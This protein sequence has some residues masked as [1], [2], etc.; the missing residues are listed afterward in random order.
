MAILA[1][2]DDNAMAYGEAYQDDSTPAGHF[3]LVAVMDDFT[4]VYLLEGEV[5]D[6]TAVIKGRVELDT[7]GKA[8]NKVYLNGNLG[9]GSGTKHP[10]TFKDA[11]AK[12]V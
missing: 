6:F 2:I 11:F 4:A 7:T 5:D 1:D 9:G 3:A 10:G 12:M 8:T